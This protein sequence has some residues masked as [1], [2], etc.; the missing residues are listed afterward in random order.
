MR[1]LVVAVALVALSAGCSD[2]QATEDTSW[3]HSDDPVPTSGLPFAV[4]DTVHLADR[5]VDAGI[6]IA[7][8]VVAGDGVYFIE[9]DD[10][11]DGNRPSRGTRELRFS[12]ADGEV[13]D[14][15]VDVLVETL[16]ASPDGRYLA[17]ID[18][19]SGEEDAFG[20]PQAAL[21]VWDLRTG[22]EIIRSSS[23]TGDPAEDDFA[24][25]YPELEMNI[26]SIDDDG[27]RLDAVGT[28]SFDFVTGEGERLADDTGEAPAPLVSPDGTWRIDQR[29]KPQVLLGPGGVQLA[30]DAER[31]RLELYGWAD[32]TTAYGVLDG[33][34]AAVMT[35]EV[36]SGACSEVADTAGRYVV[37]PNGLA[38]GGLDLSDV[39]SD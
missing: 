27:L 17:A 5:A 2:P 30:P 37:L 31:A 13:V 1:A 23:A 8:F 36:P 34:P 33:A 25:L 20:T 26:S 24:A 11:D 28:W 6:A 9:D 4:G 16:R 29:G 19:A 18:M 32:D 14:T 3:Q 7:A 35:C 10:P 12:A 38:N 39:A 22:E 21:V 15:G